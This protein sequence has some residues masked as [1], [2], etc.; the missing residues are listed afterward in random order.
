MNPQNPQTYITIEINSPRDRVVSKDP[1]AIGKWQIFQTLCHM[2]E[3]IKCPSD[4][5]TER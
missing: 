4:R 1:K 5:R 3:I 2:A